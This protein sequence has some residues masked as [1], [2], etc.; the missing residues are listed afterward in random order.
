MKNIVLI[1]PFRSYIA[2]VP[3]VRCATCWTTDRACGGGAWP[4]AVCVLDMCGPLL[5]IALLVVF[6]QINVLSPLEPWSQPV[7][8]Q[9]SQPC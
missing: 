7:A 1:Y 8:A 6:V 3:S 4:G 9:F 5:D 2:M